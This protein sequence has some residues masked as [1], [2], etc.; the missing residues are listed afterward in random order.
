MK[1]QETD[2]DLLRAYGIYVTVTFMPSR[3][4]GYVERYKDYYFVWINENKSFETMWEILLH[5]ILHIMKNDFD[6]KVKIEKLEKSIYER[7]VE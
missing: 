1:E 7:E 5:E 2:E 3:L 6:S 4:Y